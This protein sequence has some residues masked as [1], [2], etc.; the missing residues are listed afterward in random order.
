MT[1]W[2]SLHFHKEC[3][4][5]SCQSSTVRHFWFYLCS[6]NSQP[7]HSL[8]YW[9]QRMTTPNWGRRHQHY[10]RAS[11]P[12]KQS[13]NY[14][15]KW[16]LFYC[17]KQLKKLQFIPIISIITQSFLRDSFPMLTTRVCKIFFCLHGCDTALGFIDFERFGNNS[18]QN[19]THDIVDQA[20]SCH[21][22]SKNVSQGKERVG[23]IKRVA[24]TFIHCCCC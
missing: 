11:M 4:G 12:L 13:H 14:L 2:L 19:Q 7:L 20:K 16:M 10:Q 3:A 23:R 1:E 9:E 21:L 8:H 15:Y 18:E 17:N 6:L 22:G 24:L 5:S